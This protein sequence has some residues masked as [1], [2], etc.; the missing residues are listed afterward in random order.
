MKKFDIDKLPERTRSIYESQIKWGE[1]CWKNTL[2]EEG[3]DIEILLQG[4]ELFDIWERF[5]KGKFKGVDSKF[6]PEIFMDAY[7]SINFTCMGLYKQSNAS[8]RLQLE[9]VLRL[10]YFSQHPVEFK[11]WSREDNYFKKKDVWADGF[12]YFKRLEEY[13]NFVGKCKN[14]NCGI[15]FFTKVGSLYGKLSTF[16]HGGPTSF[17]TSGGNFSPKY[18]KADFNKWKATFI[19]LECYI[20]IMLILGFPDEFKGM[21]ESDQRKILKSI[22]NIKF[23]KS[24]IQTLGIKFRGRV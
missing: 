6:I 5:L 11:W 13:R 12:D 3:K 7:L 14:N 2:K 19:D 23:K 9:S 4:I 10:I 18:K 24:I 1:A 17:Q 20:H 21:P 15:N 8:M 22:R 16:V